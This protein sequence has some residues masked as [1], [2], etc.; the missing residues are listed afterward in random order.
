[1]IPVQQQMMDLVT[2]HVWVAQI[3]QLAIMM[4]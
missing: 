4:H 1:M 2:I 3:Q